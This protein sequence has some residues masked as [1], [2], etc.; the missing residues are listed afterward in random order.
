[1]PKKDDRIRSA[2]YVDLLK[3]LLEGGMGIEEAENFLSTKVHGVQ[4]QVPKGK[5]GATL[6]ALEKISVVGG[7]VSIPFFFALNRYE[8]F[9]Q[10]AEEATGQKVLHVD[11]AGSERKPN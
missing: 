1:M 8:Q 6:E 5:L 4:L 2:D 7:A 3:S 11:P 9:I 10:L